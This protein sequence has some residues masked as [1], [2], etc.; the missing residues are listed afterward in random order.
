[1]VI[2]S[3]I[4]AWKIL[5]TEQPG[6]LQPMGLQRAE[7]LTHSVLGVGKRLSGGILKR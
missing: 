7:Q 2:H 3:S 5:W 1:M 4:L 6:E